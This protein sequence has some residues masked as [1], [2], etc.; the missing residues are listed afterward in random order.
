VAASSRRDIGSDLRDAYGHAL[1]DYL[2]GKGR[3]YEIV[4]RDDGYVDVS[5]GPGMYLAAYPKWPFRHRQALRYAKGRVLDVGCGAGRHA[6]Y[7]QAKDLDV[8]GID[9]SPLAVAVCHRRGVRDVRLMS[10]NQ[11]GPAL[12]TF[13]TVL[14]LGNNFGLFANPRRARWLL[15]RLHAITDR[16]ARIIAES[17][18]IYQTDNPFHRPY[19]RRNRQRGRM[20]GQVRMR[21]RYQK[22]AT[23][24]FD[25]LF[26]SRMEMQKI[27]SGTGWAVKR[28][29]PPRGPF[30]VA[31]IIKAG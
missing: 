26:V 3:G 16:D 20:P 5:G 27:L 25:Y 1:S 6:L 10:V 28:F 7:L 19:H 24:W 30:Y 8:L 15:G 4:E 12:G 31:V 14:M 9:A 23:P 21:V 11:I 29:L 17:V 18:D 13:T 22:Y 2:H